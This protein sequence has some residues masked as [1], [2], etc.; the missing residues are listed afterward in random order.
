[1]VPESVFPVQVTVARYSW[2]RTAANYQHRRGGW[3]IPPH[4]L[5][6]VTQGG[7]AVSCGPPTQEGSGGTC[8]RTRRMSAHKVGEIS[9]AHLTCDPVV[10]TLACPGAKSAPQHSGLTRRL[11]RTR[12]ER[13]YQPPLELTGHGAPYPHGE[14]NPGY[15]LERV[16]S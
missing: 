10:T 14:S 7:P 16:M 8:A 9:R 4:L 11:S 1:M 12:P 3:G 15:H 5:R 6:G 13:T 2:V